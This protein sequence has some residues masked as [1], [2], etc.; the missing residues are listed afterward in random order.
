MYLWVAHTRICIFKFTSCFEFNIVFLCFI[1]EALLSAFLY[2]LSLGRNIT[3]RE[4]Y[5]HV[6]RESKPVA[7]KQYFIKVLANNLARTDILN[8]SNE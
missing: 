6:R 5:F 8:Y 1:T 4:V 2:Q 7:L 3:N